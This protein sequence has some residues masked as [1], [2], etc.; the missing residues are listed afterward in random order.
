MR[1]FKK[2]LK[3]L[4]YIEGLQVDWLLFYLTGE[5]LEHVRGAGS[6]QLSV[7]DLGCGKGGDLLKW[8]RGGISHLV[9][10]GHQLSLINITYSSDQM[11]SGALTSVCFSASSTPSP[12]PDQTKP[13]PPCLGG[14]GG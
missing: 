8:R 12:S 7:L 10:A 4:T 1:I 2:H 11:L 14:L 3:D 6:Q 9:C 5:I 13:F